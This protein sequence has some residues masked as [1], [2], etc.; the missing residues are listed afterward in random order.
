MYVMQNA[1]TRTDRYPYAAQFDGTAYQRHAVTAVM[2]AYSGETQ[3]YVMDEQDPI[4]ATWRAGLPGA[5]HGPGRDARRHRRRTCGT[6][7]T[8]STTRPPR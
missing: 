7:R 2:D 1:Y 5:V 8:S 4:I 6:A 3:L